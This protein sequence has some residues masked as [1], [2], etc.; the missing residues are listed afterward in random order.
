MTSLLH[1]DLEN[2]FEECIDLA[3]DYCIY[4]LVDAAQDRFFC[5]K[6]SHL[7]MRNLLTEA[8]GEKAAEI[9]PY[10]VKLSHYSNN[11]EWQYIS[12]K[13]VGTSIMTFIV[14]ELSFNDLYDHLRQFTNVKFEGGLEMYLA[15][16]DPMILGTL[17]GQKSDKTLYVN[18]QVLSVEQKK[19][20]LEPIFSW[21]YWDRLKQLHTIKGKNKSEFVKFYDW[22]RHFEF[23][24]EQEE[25]MVEATFPDHLIYFLKLNNPFL[26][27]DFN[28]WA[29]YQY[30]VEKIALARE[31]DLKG[32]RDILN[33]ICLTLTYKNNFEQDS[34]LQS[35]LIEVEKKIITMD[36]LMEN[37]VEMG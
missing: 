3:N 31:Y 10:L 9:S 30:V 11:L 27:E 20:L 18:K 25:L 34:T 7:Q 4:G 19:I 8:A 2:F 17:V 15:F 33:F 32:T 24:I 6:N 23:T 37:L 1:A 28:E 22:Q 5:K 36:Q 35:L 13:V 26:V 21:L 14:T 12:K 16:W 29:L